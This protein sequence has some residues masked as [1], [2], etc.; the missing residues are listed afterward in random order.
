MDNYS[1]PDNGMWSRKGY[2]Q[3]KNQK[4]SHSQA[5]EAFQER[6]GNGQRGNQ[7]ACQRW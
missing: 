5:I 1:S 7:P 4:A 6:L 3:K 2:L